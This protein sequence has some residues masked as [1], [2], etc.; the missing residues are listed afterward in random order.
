L[1]LLDFFGCSTGVSVV[2]PDIFV[3]FATGAFT[4]NNGAGE[5]PLF[6]RATLLN[7]VAGLDLRLGELEWLP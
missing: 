6:V 5:F 3:T 4:A 2:G 1:G 7:N